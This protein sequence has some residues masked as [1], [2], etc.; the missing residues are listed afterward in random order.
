MQA[1]RN[2]GELNMECPFRDRS[3][4]G[5]VLAQELGA[6][7]RREDVIVLALPRGGVPVAFEVARSLQAPLDV[8]VVRKLGVP[9]HEE[10]AMGAIASGGVLV[11]EPSVIEDLAIPPDVVADVAAREEWERLRRER[12]YRDDR[13]EPDVRGRTII[14]VDD[15]LATGSTMRAAVAALRK[16]QPARIVV[17]VPVAA[18]SACADLAP[19]V[20]EIVCARTPETFRSVGWWY[21]DFSQ[22]TDEEV[23]DLLARAERETSHRE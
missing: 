2:P 10:L 12:E 18:P 8:F 22:T 21:L 23:R 16:F 5:Q 19:E 15:G 13:P 1:N 11:L 3:E 6:Y 20:D 4:A 17:A 9:G 14:L 7:A